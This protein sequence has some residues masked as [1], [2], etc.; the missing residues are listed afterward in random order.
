[1]IWKPAEVLPEGFSGSLIHN[2]KEILVAVLID[3]MGG[4]CATYKN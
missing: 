3:S 1:V 4:G 2:Q